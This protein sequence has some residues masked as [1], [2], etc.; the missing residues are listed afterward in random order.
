M[1]PGK[2]V[3]IVDCDI[4]Q[5]TP[6]DLVI[7]YYAT[8]PL[9][10]ASRPYVHRALEE[11]LMSCAHKSVNKKFYK[12]RGLEQS[13]V[14]F[15]LSLSEADYGIYYVHNQSDVAFKETVTFTKLKGYKLMPPHGGT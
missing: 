11:T 3:V 9:N 4:K 8:F 15:D 6:I 2:Y 10:L 7:A 1:K 13:Y 12:E 5:N 14:C